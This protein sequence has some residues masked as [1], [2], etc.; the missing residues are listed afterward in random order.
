MLNYI[1]Q[2]LD[3]KL[4]VTL[5]LSTGQSLDIRTVKSTSATTIECES[6]SSSSLYLVRLDAIIFV[7]TNRII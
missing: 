1:T 4:G 7:E 2:A 6:S 3:Q 5:H